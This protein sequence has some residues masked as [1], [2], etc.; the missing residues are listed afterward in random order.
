MELSSPKINKF[1][2]FLEK[3]LS[4]LIFFLYFR[5]TRSK[6]ILIFREMEIYSLK[7]KKLFFFRRELSKPEKQTKKLL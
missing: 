7:L 3:E 4:S 6:K 1:L 2:I 5:K